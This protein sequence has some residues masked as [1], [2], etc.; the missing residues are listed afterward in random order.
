MILVSIAS[1]ALLEV[2]QIFLLNV[3]FNMDGKIH[4]IRSFGFLGMF[5]L[6]NQVKC[7]F[8]NQL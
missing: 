5:L 7:L 4:C 8:F 2:R 1:L 6:L 3:E